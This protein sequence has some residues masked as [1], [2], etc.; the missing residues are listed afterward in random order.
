MSFPRNLFKRPR[1][2]SV[3]ADTAQGIINEVETG[4]KDNLV[5]LYN[6]QPV[7]EIARRATDIHKSQEI[8]DS[9]K[10]LLERLREIL[11]TYEGELSQYEQILQEHERFLLIK[12]TALNNLQ[13][14]VNRKER[15][16]NILLKRLQRTDKEVERR[17]IQINQKMYV[18]GGQF[19]HSYSTRVMPCKQ[20]IMNLKS[21]V[22]RI[23]D[24]A[25][26][27][28]EDIQAVRARAAMRIRENGNYIKLI[29]PNEFNDFESVLRA[30]DD[31]KEML[32][33]L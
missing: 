2:V 18:V 17:I 29:Y 24:E 3:T 7:D 28:D 21:S 10:K 22:R 13:Y 26:V 8:N 23:C 12:N 32:D 15:E 1:P 11:D 14:A 25:S 27:D 9:I 6:A 16:L 31:I 4:F 30:L 19:M 5:T 20:M 33:M